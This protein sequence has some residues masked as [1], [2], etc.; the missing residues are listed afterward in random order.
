MLLNNNYLILLKL[1][2]SVCFAAG[3]TVFYRKSFQLKWTWTVLG[4][5]LT[6]YTTSSP[7]PFNL[8]TSV[9]A[10]TISYY[11]WTILKGCD[12]WTFLTFLVAIM[13]PSTLLPFNRTTV[14]IAIA[15]IAAVPQF[16]RCQPL[17]SKLRELR[18]RLGPV[19]I[20]YVLRTALLVYNIDKTGGQ[21]LFFS[22]FVAILAGVLFR[23]D[24][25]VLLSLL[26][27]GIQ[28]HRRRCCHRSLMIFSF[29]WFM[30]VVSFLIFFIYKNDMY[31]DLNLI[32]MWII[33]SRFFKR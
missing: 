19:Y 10:T 11:S 21:M 31:D 3:A 13:D 25:G 29:V 32:E 15:M 27:V 16:I 1:L 33:F 30:V 14:T 23:P 18:A 5:I 22:F 4:F 28:A 7:Y 2:Q 20:L 26:I 9:I 24:N 8:L 6:G 12:T 17:R